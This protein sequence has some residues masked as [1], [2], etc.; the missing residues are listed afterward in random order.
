MPDCLGMCGP[1]QVRKFEYDVREAKIVKAEPKPDGDEWGWPKPDNEEI[2]KAFKKKVE[3]LEKHRP[4]ADAKKCDGGCE[5]R[6]LPPS[7]TEKG[8]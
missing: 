7:F 6:H 4:M 2:E 8:L 1:Y 3:E 5:C